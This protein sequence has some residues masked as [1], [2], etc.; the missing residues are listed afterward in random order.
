LDVFR[1][2]GAGERCG[3]S[4]LKTAD[5]SSTTPNVSFCYE[6]AKRVFDVVVAALALLLMF[7]FLVFIALVVKLEY[8]QVSPI[9]T[10][11]RVG[12]NGSV[13]TFIKFRTMV[14]D[15]DERK[16]ALLDRNE[17]EGGI[18][19]K[20]RKDPRITPVGRL[21]R[22]FYLDE[23]PQL[24][25]VLV[26]DMSLVGPRPPLP[27]EVAQ[28][29]ARHRTRLAVRPGIT[30]SW[31]VGLGTSSAKGFEAQVDTD[32]QY[33]SK[34]GALLDLHILARTIW[35]LMNGRGF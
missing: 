31:Q 21:L 28:Y 5:E 30:C 12:K 11:R 8:R 22:R 16:A 29:G 32:L 24:F 34:R 26:G 9:Y 14:P 20:L 2:L 23:L 17:I 10:Q 13:F 19:F 27:E 33:I 3:V 6:G 7:P 18:T 35:Y 25:N 4:I 1:N 15:A